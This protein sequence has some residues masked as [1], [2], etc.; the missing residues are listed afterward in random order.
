MFI[1]GSNDIAQNQRNFNVLGHRAIKANKIV[2]KN[3]FKIFPMALISPSI[4]KSLKRT[5]N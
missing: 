4:F 1:C 5:K 3:L 2:I